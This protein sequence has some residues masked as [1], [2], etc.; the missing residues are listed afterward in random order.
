MGTGR[1]TLEG[2][3][4]CLFYGPMLIRRSHANGVVTYQS[5]R[6][7]RI[8]AAH[9]F[10]TRLAG[11]RGPA[12][13]DLDLAEPSAPEPMDGQRTSNLVTH[14][15]LV[16]QSIG[17]GSYTRF[18]LDQVHGS[19]VQIIDPRGAANA[20]ADAAVTDMENTLLA[21]RT[22]DCVPILLAGPIGRVG[23]RVVGAIHAGWRG[24]VA[25]VVAAT[26]QVLGD[27]F[28]IGPSQ[29][30]VAVGP[31]ISVTA[32]EVGFEVSGAFGR[33][34]L[35][36]AIHLADGDKP[37]VDLRSAVITQLLTLGVPAEEIDTTDRCT[38]RDQHEFFSHRRNERGRMAAVIGI[39]SE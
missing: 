20:Q 22:A 30:V 5:P 23:P 10:T 13:T 36:D 2:F 16:Q 3:G 18:T 26:I 32:Y 11:T 28:D 7:N 1:S 14:W 12:Q 38:H 21:V 33:I 37:H 29:L 15:G 25:S 34:G 8:G 31:C 39:K 24:V 35:H 6:L 27:R 9:A 19:R 17:C 4:L